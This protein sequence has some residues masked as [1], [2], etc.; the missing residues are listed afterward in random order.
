MRQQSAPVTEIIK[1]WAL[2]QKA[3]PGSAFR[4]PLEYMLELW[5]GLPVV[6]HN[7]RVPG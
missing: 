7:P 6:L 5:S 2:A 1:Q 4:K 3:L